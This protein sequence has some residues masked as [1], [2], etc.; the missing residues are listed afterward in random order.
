MSESKSGW[1]TPIILIGAL[2]I[3]GYFLWNYLKNTGLGQA[4][5][6]A[7]SPLI[8]GQTGGVGAITPLQLAFPITMLPNIADTLSGI[9]SSVSSGADTFVKNNVADI[10]GLI[11]NIGILLGNKPTVAV[12]NTQAQIVANANQ[13]AIVKNI[14]KYATGKYVALATNQIYP[15][16]NPS[17]QIANF[18]VSPK[19]IKVNGISRKVM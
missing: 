2:A 7:T 9:P 18:N 8:Q 16:N 5:N 6:A 14:P 3:G 17:N 11:T 15:Q 13:A 19:I 12:G 4:V 10:N 1:A